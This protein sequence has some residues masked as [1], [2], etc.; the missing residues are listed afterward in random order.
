MEF[1]SLVA[2]LTQ[3][4]TVVSTQILDQFSLPWFSLGDAL[5][6][7]IVIISETGDPTAPTAVVAIDSSSGIALTDGAGVIYAQA[8]NLQVTNINELTFDMVVNTA[9]LVAAL[10][11]SEDSSVEAFLEV[12]ITK[13]SQDELLLREATSIVKT[14]TSTLPVPVLPVRV[15]YN[16]TITSLRGDV[17]SLDTIATVSL[18]TG[19]LLITVIDNIVQMWLLVDGAADGGDPDGQVAPL[20]YD[21]GTNDRHWVKAIGF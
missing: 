19:T 8:T 1:L 18:G 20:D 14:A 6:G 5:S 11:A 13:D 4:A 2:S 7:K 12:R 17:T 16:S 9:E 10:T 15:M 21:A 3:R